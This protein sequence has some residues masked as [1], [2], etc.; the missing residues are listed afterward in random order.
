MDKAEQQEHRESL[1]KVVHELINQIDE[2][3]AEWVFCAVRQKD[4]NIRWIISGEYNPYIV[5]GFL[6]TRANQ[7]TRLYE[8]KEDEET[9]D[10]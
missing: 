9:T 8:D 2:E 10:Q 6:I 3:T 5:S 7:I 4:G 1:L